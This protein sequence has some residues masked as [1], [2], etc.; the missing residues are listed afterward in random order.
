M[1]TRAETASG[2]LLLV[3]FP[4]SFTITYTCFLISVCLQRCIL[5]IPI[6]K[7]RSWVTY[8]NFIFPSWISGDLVQPICS[9]YVHEHNLKVVT[10][11]GITEALVVD[12]N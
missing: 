11:A 12:N 7:S 3:S 8:L 9:S 4:N 1:G 2:L 6:P 10:I 5:Q